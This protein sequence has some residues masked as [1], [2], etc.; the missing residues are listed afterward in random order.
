MIEDIIKDL[1][2]KDGEYSKDGSYVVNLEDSDEFG[3]VFSRLD[4]NEDYEELTE[5]SL[6]SLFDTSLIWLK[7]NFQINLIAD[8]TQDSYKLVITEIEDDKEWAKIE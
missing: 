1:N 7:D 8:L 5:N 3:R 6:I 2:I 4:R